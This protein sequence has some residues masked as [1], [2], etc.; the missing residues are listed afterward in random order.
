MKYYSYHEQQD[1]QIHDKLRELLNQLPP[2]C[3]TYFRA[4]E[5][6]T[7][8]RTRL[9]YAYDLHVFFSFLLQE[10]PALEQSDMRSLK[11]TLLDQLTGRDLEEYVEYLKYR[12]DD[13]AQD[14][15]KVNKE[16]GLKRKISSLKSFYNY[17]F[18]TEQIRTNPAAFLKLPKMHEKE[19]IRLDYDEVARLLDEVDSGEH[20]TKRQQDYHKKTRVRDIAL[21]SLL[22]GTG[23]RISECVGIDLN[24]LDLDETKL[25]VHRKGGKEEMIFFSD[26]VAAALSPYL[27]ARQKMEPADENSQNALFLSMQNKRLAV[28]SAENL[29]KKYARI[30]TPLK[31]ITPHKLRSTFG[32]HLYQ[33]TGDIY[34]VADVLGHADVNTTRKHYAAIEE[35]RRRAARGAVKLR[36]S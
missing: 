15:I 35:D 8:S 1:K 9:A 14:G 12:P 11:L 16:S 5:P 13:T 18:E 30:V 22:L 20:L 31:H 24:D 6:R 7:E 32:T 17:F 21:I 36:S 27:Q 10:N 2:F 29:V 25:K 28:R 23:I 4:I 3:R 19:I 33:E 34:L 26:E